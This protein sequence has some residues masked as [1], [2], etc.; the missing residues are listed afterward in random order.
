MANGFVTFLEKAGKDILKVITLGAIAA[1]DVA[2]IV[3]LADPAL[4]ALINGT[5]AAILTAEA[6]GSAA[7]ATAP[8]TDTGAQK[9]ALVISSIEPLALEFAKSQGLPQPTQAQLQKWVDGFVAAL[10]AFEVPASPAA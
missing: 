9:A 10:N 3:S 8:S 7:A 5:A 1:K 6:T 2:P 4:G